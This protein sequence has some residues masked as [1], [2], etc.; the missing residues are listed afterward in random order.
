MDELGRAGRYD[1][2]RRLLEASEY[3]ESAICAKLGLPRLAD[4]DMEPSRRAP[5]PA[6]TDAADVLIRLFLAGDALE[7]AAVDAYVDSQASELLVAMG[8]LEST[9]EGRYVATVAL[10]PVDGIFIASD[11]WSHPDGSPFVAPSDTVYPALVRNTRLFLDLL[12]AEPCERCLDLGSGTGIGA[13]VA[14]RNGAREA[15]AADIADRSTRFAEFNRRLNGLTAVSTVTSDLYE[16]LKGQTFDRIVAHPPYMPVLSAKWVFL[17]GG[18]DGEQITRRIVEGLP[19]HLQEGGLCCCL[20]MGT[21]RRGAGGTEV[22]FELRVREWLGGA[23]DQF[24]V[25]L[26]VRRVV[27]PQQFAMSTAPFEPRSRADAH[28]WRELFARLGVVS[29]VYGFLLIRRRSRRSGAA[30]TIRRM[31]APDFGRADWQWMLAWETVAAGEQANP[32]ILDSRLFAARRTE[33]EVVHNLSAGGWTPRSYQLRIDRPF[34][35]N[36]SAE[37]WAANLIALCDGQL[38]GRQH[39]E[40]FTAQGFIPEGTTA[41]DFADAVAP[42]VSGGFIEVDGFRPPRAAE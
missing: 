31:A 3:T 4:Y 11:R 19:E 41:D 26:V 1:E 29:L 18:E 36:C 14:Q 2:L 12:P 37:P 28:A 30:L 8:L 21:D 34:A 7:R 33:F 16:A 38:T 15:W 6:P 24:D 27:E 10:Y 40:R 39:F 17:S 42:L 35:M 5:L 22:P 25:A 20:T 13:F 32:A 9:A 23:A